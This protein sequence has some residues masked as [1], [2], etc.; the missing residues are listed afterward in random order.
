MYCRLQ[1]QIPLVKRLEGLSAE[2]LTNAVKIIFTEC[3]I[4]HKIMS[5]AGKNFVSD[6]FL[7]FCRAINV[8]QATLLVYQ[9]NGQVEAC[10]KFI[11]QMFKKMCQIW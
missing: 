9:S 6:R 5:D 8:E 3:G 7:K 10:I 4:P 1:Q 11:K 2:N